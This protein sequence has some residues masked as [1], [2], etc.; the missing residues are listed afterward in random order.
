MIKLQVG[1]NY[2]LTKKVSK[3]G[4]VEKEERKMKL[5]GIYRYHAVFLNEY[6]YRES[7]TYQDLR[8]VLN[9]KPINKTWRRGC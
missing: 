3:G 6:G 4:I 1:E 8:C 2:F 7:F 5:V 9:G